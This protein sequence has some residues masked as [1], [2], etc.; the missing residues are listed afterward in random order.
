MSGQDSK[1]ARH[2]QWQARFKAALAGMASGASRRATE[3]D[4]LISPEPSARGCWGYRRRVGDAVVV[5][6]VGSTWQ[7]RRLAAQAVGRQNRARTIGAQRGYGPC[8][9]L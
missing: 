3:I 8:R 2:R 7:Q 9:K 1:R 6:L 4:L 5:A